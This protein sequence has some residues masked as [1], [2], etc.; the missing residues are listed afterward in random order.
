MRQQDLVTR[1]APTD[2]R[3]PEGPQALYQRWINEL[4]AGETIARELVSDDFVGHWP[5]R[6]IHG[7]DELQAIVDD[8]RSQLREL[9]FV[10]DVGPFVDGDL[11]AARWISTGSNKRGP[12][13]FTGND[14]LRVADGRIV[15]YWT[16]TSPG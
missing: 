5:T 12:A 14:I 9:M 13:R 16:G 7:P 2:T 6:D 3:D 15:E 4:W 8:T 11:V 1:Q 10:I